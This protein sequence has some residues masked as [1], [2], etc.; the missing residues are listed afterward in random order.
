MLVTHSFS[1]NRVDCCTWS[2]S[3]LHKSICYMCNEARYFL[4]LQKICN[5]KLFSLNPSLWVVCFSKGEHKHSNMVYTSAQQHKSLHVITLLRLKHTGSFSTDQWQ[6]TNS[7]S[8]SDTTALITT[9]IWLWQKNTKTDER[10]RQKWW[11]AAFPAALSDRISVFP[12]TTQC[13]L[14]QQSPTIPLNTYL[15]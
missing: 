10:G 3:L 2:N 12:V 4:W 1:L 6:M 9:N 7:L 15:H 11:H 13:W 5:I 14:I 8:A